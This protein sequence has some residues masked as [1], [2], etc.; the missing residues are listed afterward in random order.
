[1]N[2]SPD[3]LFT[4][5]YPGRLIIIGRDA[6]GRNHIVVYAVTGRSPA[7]Q[8][9]ELV[10][11]DRAVWTR[12]TDP[13][14]LAGGNP[15]L[16]IYPAVLLGPGI[17]VSNGKQTADID[18]AAGPS[19]A[20]VLAASLKAWTFEPDEPIFTPR[21]S[22]CVL[23]DGEAGLHIVRRG[24]GGEAERL[25][26]TFRAAPG[27]GKMISTYA[28]PNEQP[29]PV[30]RGEPVDVALPGPTARATAKAVY[31]SLAPADESETDF[32]VAVACVF[33]RAADLSEIEF[34]VI[35]RHERKTP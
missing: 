16:L 28:G 6:S 22:G 24:A 35:N 1:M 26:F 34:A 27:C 10:R 14:V 30:F 29:L 13:A 19:A 25:V 21:I 2:A 15:D 31:S 17:A 8:A 7:S 4:T 5:T 33:A 11:L 3:R 32:R 9:R 20:E 18:P 23:P 12:P